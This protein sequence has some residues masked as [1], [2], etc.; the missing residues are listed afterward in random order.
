M[1]EFWLW[2]L[3]IGIF[4]VATGLFI[5]SLILIGGKNE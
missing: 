1:N 3:S 5:Y 2:V 4:I